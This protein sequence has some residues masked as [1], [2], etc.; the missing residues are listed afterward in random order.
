MVSVVEFDRVTKTYSSGRGISD[1]S[2]KI[3]AH[4]RVGLFGLNGSGKTTTLK[5]LS[6]LLPA[7]SG[8]VLINN[9]PPKTNRRNF[10]LLSDRQTFPSWMSL[11]DVEYTMRGLFVNFRYQL[12]RQ[13]RQ[14]LEVPSHRVGQMSKGQLQRLKISAFLAIDTD[15]YLL[16]EPLA[17]IDVI[18]R[19]KIIDAVLRHAQGVCLVST[20]EIREVATMLNRV[21]IVS[22]GRLCR[23]L[24]YDAKSQSPEY[25]VEQ[26]VKAVSK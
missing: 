19:Q 12:F 21:L 22:N 10:A 14:H 1:F 9:Q 13:L 2:F 20:H 23:D 25:L 24:S 11:T 4:E 16:D 8:K 3:A 17:G 6:G 26:F 18:S 5:L 15:L 7:T